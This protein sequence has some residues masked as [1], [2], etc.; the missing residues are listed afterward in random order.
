MTNQ[1]PQT[2]LP[3]FGIQLVGESVSWPE[4]RCAAQAIE[5]F[6]FD[7]LWNH[8]HLL[9]VF[10]DR[11]EAI[12]ETLTTLTALALSTSRIRIGTLVNG[13]MY[14]HP[15]ILAKQA[16]MIDVLSEGRLEFALGASWATP[17]F[18]AYGLPFP[19]AG[20]R[21]ARLD[22]ALQIVRALWTDEETTF[23]GRYYQLTGAWCQPKPVQ[24]PHPPIMVGGGGEEKTLR[25]VARHADIWGGEVGPDA[26]TR[27]IGLIRRYCAEIGRDPAEIEMSVHPTLAIA[28]TVS[29]A[30][31]TA[32]ATARRRRQPLERLQEDGLFG[33]PEAIIERMHAYREAG[34]SHWIMALVPPF[35]LD[36][37]R[38]FAEKVIPAFR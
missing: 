20:E 1:F 3:R 10:G 6:G 15:A 4:F 24:Q 18:Q 2:R 16:A 23:A 11:G 5:S 26:C 17:E 33:T 30:R 21:I 25:V 9:P 19:T 34:V 13:V 12:F 32:E 14:R 29:A 22:E 27:K 35:D 38:L 36:Q 28:P 37:A 7:T 31:A 8:D